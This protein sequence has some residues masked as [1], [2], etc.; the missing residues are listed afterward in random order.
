M[1]RFFLFIGIIF[2]LN[3]CKDNE[4]KND[5]V[6]KPIALNDSLDCESIEIIKKYLRVPENE[7]PQWLKTHS[8]EM[9]NISLASCID[10]FH[11][12][13]DETDFKKLYNEHP[14]N[15]PNPKYYKKT[16]KEISEF[17][18]DVKC[19]E[20]YLGFDFEDENEDGVQEITLKLVDFSKKRS[21]YSLTFL[22]ALNEIYD[23]DNN[24]YTFYFVK[25]KSTIQTTPVIKKVESVIF[26]IEIS[27]GNFHF[28][29]IISDPTLVGY[30]I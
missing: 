4:Q 11:L 30:K 1:K 23:L 15:N 16:W 20:K 3:S 12:I 29:N 5:K 2:L 27:P 14:D 9:C 24:N 22:K 6:Q 26:K 13:F 21:C 17:I 28:F 10:D 7:R 25:A 18:G 8:D 19:Y